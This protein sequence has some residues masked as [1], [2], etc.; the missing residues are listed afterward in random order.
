MP[1]QGRRQHL[2]ALFPPGPDVKTAGERLRHELLDWVSSRSSEVTG[3][4]A[5]AAALEERP[6][7]R[8]LRLH[9]AQGIAQEPVHSLCDEIQQAQQPG[10]SAAI[11]VE[12]Q[13]D[14]V[15]LDAAEVM[16]EVATADPEQQRRQVEAALAVARSEI[17]ALGT[18]PVRLAAVVAQVAAAQPQLRDELEEMLWNHLYE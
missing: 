12:L 16:A 5:M 8:V 11:A 4:L 18:W 17:A 9:L 14:A 6:T 1:Q 13:W 15:R 2:G 7:T 3:E 10:G